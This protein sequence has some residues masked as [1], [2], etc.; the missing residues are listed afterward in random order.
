VY[1]G[2]GIPQRVLVRLAEGKTHDPYDNLTVRE[3]QVLQLVVE[4]KTSREVAE[5]LKVS[6]KT[7]DT[8]RAHLMRKLNLPNHTALVKFA[9]QRG[10]VQVD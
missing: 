6:P 9:I 1:L 3:R 2:P 8:H 10:I 7:V 5:I 4:G